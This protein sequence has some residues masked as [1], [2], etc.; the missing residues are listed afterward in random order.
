M[1]YHSYSNYNLIL[2]N[3]PFKRT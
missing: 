3:K 2:A 1:F